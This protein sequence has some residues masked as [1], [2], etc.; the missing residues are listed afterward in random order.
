MS[1]SSPLFSIVLIARNEERTLPRL[2]NSLEPFIARAGE[3]LVM[4]TSST[5]DTASVAKRLGCQVVSVKDRF[6]SELSEEHVA[7]IE[8]NFCHR[9]EAP[10]AQPGQRLF[11]FGEARQAA[12]AL[13]SNDFVLQLDAS[14]EVSAFDIGS[15]N[16]WIGS[17]RAASFEYELVYGVYRLRIAR[18]CD[19]NLFHWEGRIHEVLVPNTGA[20]LSS[21]SK[22]R[23]DTQLVVSHSQQEKERNYLAGLALQVLETPDKPRWWHFLGRQLFYHGRYNSAIA[24]LKTHAAMETAWNAERSQSWCFIANCLEAIEH[25]AEAEE[26]CHRAIELDH[27]RREPFL[28]L[29]AL[30]SRRRDF[31]GAVR[32]ARESLGIPRTNAYPEFAANYT[33][34]PH[35]LLYWNLFWLGR[36]AEAREHWEKF[37]SMVPEEDIPK[38]HPRMFPKNCGN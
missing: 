4:D 20:D 2:L 30:C 28:A 29:A 32:W 37:V 17:G 11:N 3:V 21:R 5:D 14:D 7:S 34:R 35:S 18:F 22:I 24:V 9:G 23:C 27:T 12:G 38:D 31:A 15:F 1:W 26:A 33:W 8:R 16:E 25:Q 13:A 36:R 10:L 19:R 6:D